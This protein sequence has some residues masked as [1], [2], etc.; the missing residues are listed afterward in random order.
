VEKTF[1]IANYTAEKTADRIRE[2]RSHLHEEL[3]PGARGHLQS[4]FLTPFVEYLDRQ[5]ERFEASLPGP[6]DVIAWTTRNLLEFCSLI[7]QVFVNEESRAQFFGEVYVDSEEIKTRLENLG[8]PRHLLSGRSS[9]AR[10]PC[11][12]I[13]S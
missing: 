9:S 3:L 7:T 6:L 8:I 12:W 13:H 1:D 11:G 10:G 2:L 5:A 4:N